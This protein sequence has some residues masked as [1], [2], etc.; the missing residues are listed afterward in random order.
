[1][2]FDAIYAGALVACA[3]RV[4]VMALAGNHKVLIERVD[5]ALQLAPAPTAGLFSKVMQGACAR[6]PALKGSGAAARLERL[7]DAGAWTEAALALV[8]LEAPDW[9]VRRL[10]C[11]G[12][13]WF[14]SLSRRPNLPLPLDDTVDAGHQTLSLAILRAFVGV[15][16][17]SR[18]APEAASAVPG[19]RSPA[20]GLICCDD[21]A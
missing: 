21:F 16:R 20:Q 3:R 8:E 18:T 13:E 7:I 19:V 11:E 14:C 2:A 12:G 10:V 15:R 5:E 17:R 9:K 4:R 1:M 6:L